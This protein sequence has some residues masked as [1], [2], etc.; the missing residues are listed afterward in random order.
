MPGA[1][2]DPSR[3]GPG[4]AGGGLQGNGEWSPSSFA[5]HGMPCPYK[6]FSPVRPAIRTESRVTNH[7]LSPFQLLPVMK[8]VGTDGGP[9]FVVGVAGHARAEAF[10]CADRGVFA[11]GLT[12]GAPRVR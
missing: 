1:A 7:G 6:N 5:G 11:V 3:N 12:I 4:V 8:Q 9:K 10:E 2:S